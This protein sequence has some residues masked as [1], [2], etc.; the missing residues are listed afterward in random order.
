MNRKTFA[1]MCQDEHVRI[2]HKDSEYERCPLCRVLDE[3]AALKAALRALDRFYQADDFNIIDPEG[4]FVFWRDLA[5]LLGDLE[6]E[7]PK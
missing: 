4:D 6:Q 5:G 3:L 7:P 1:H 2:G